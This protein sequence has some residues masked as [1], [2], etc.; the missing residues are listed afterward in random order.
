[1]EKY[2]CIHGH[3]YQPPRENAWLGDVELQDGAYP[4]HDWNERITA[5]CYAPNTASRIVD[6]NIKILD[7]INNYSLISFNVGPTLLSWLARHKPDVYGAIIEADRLSRGNFSG[8]GSALA[9]VYNHM[10]MPLAN[11]RDKET[12]VIWG[13]RDFIRR[14]A[15]EPEG[16]WLPETA[17][18]T[19][20]LE[21]LAEHNI[22]FTILAPSQ[23]KRTK[24]LEKGGRWHE[25]K[26]S[27]DPTKP[28][29]CSLP[30]GR[31][32]TLFF[33]DGPISRD[34]AFGGLLND[35]GAFAQRLLGAFSD[36]S[37]DPQLVHVATDGETYGHHH[38]YGEM[39]LSY[40]LHY[41]RSTNAARLTN[42]SEFLASH[43][44]QDQAE[45]VENSSWSCSHGVERWRDDCGDTTRS[46]PGWRQ[47]WR[48][49][50][51]QAFDRLRDQLSPLF[52]QEA[53]QYVKDPWSARNEYID[54]IH[55]NSFE[56]VKSFLARH[57][58]R[59]LSHEENVKILKLL[60]LQRNCLLMYTSCGWFFSEISDIETTQVLQYG[61]KAIQTAEELWGTPWE[62][63]FRNK[64]AE[65]P[66]NV[67]DNGKTV[68][69]LLVRP[70]RVDLLR[71]T[72]HYGISSIFAEF[73][74]RASLYC[75]T[76]E[77]EAHIKKEA[78]RFRLALGR[79]KI[80]SD[81]T[82]E[83]K[84]ISYAVLDL[85]DLNISGGVRVIDDPQEYARVQADLTEAFE[86]GNMT[87][88]LQRTMR[89]FGPNQYSLWH[90][91]KD[92]QR[93]I[94]RE[95]LAE[96]VGKIEGS[97]RDIYEANSAMMAMLTEL[98]YPVPAPFHLAAEYIMNADLQKN[99]V[100]DNLDR[101][102]LRDLIAHVKK[103]SFK[104]DRENLRYV[105]S[106]WLTSQM[107]L[108]GADRDNIPLMEKI[109]DG[110]RL[111][112]ALN[113]DLDLWKAQNIYFEISRTA[114]NDKKNQAESGDVPAKKWTA[115]FKELGS[116]LF[117]NIE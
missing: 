5:E 108:F 43:P 109:V 30:S 46:K 58:R 19:E 53:S 77:R 94:I 42:Y 59:E 56:N 66:S 37:G 55:D 7:I 40:C 86:K 81:F 9:Q 15:R 21:V 62:E 45:I 27:L 38:K 36:T 34:I 14:F 4:Y 26:G 93:R 96:A 116:F 35:G 97:Y 87:E 11:R 90:L 65:A 91:F 3:F 78:G 100:D 101:E 63:E 6:A 103:F 33:Y 104:L 69:D 52:E 83:E 20:T 70:A 16:M 31:T 79:V 80:S 29:F 1:M 8:H 71:V 48:K 73:P 107:E 64:L 50:L 84:T 18:D 25:T 76:A 114:M 39:A 49:P 74:R 75:Y 89:H 111:M 60:D 117:V 54:V 72:A 105:A 57:A 44:P 115:T 24:P 99:F 92:E 28:Y 61:S 85:G 110:L 47:A 2:I 41:I 13:I 98:G 82:W 88:V 95:I 23:A 12:Q 32:I 106:Q 113:L 22:K 17:V 10:I 67:Y 112:A 102:R 51:R 68:Y